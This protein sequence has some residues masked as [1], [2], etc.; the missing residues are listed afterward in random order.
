MYRNSRSRG[1]GRARGAMRYKPYGRS[2]D[3]EDNRIPRP[4]PEASLQGTTPQEK[5]IARAKDDLRL[6]KD[7]KTFFDKYFE[8]ERYTIP[9]PANSHLIPGEDR[10]NTKIDEIL[11]RAKT[12]CSEAI[13]AHLATEIESAEERIKNPPK[14]VELNML[15]DV[16]K[17]LKEQQRS[18]MQTMMEYIGKTMK[19]VLAQHSATPGTN[20]M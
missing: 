3:M 6:A 1:R 12:E 5:A 17:L 2:T 4:T 13:S 18:S 15:E 10:L 14:P 11:G 7:W 20:N 9:R 8:R 19:E 16:T